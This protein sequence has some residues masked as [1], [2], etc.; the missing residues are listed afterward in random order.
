MGDYGADPAPNVDNARQ[1][2]FA[3]KLAALTNLKLDQFSTAG[4]DKVLSF[5]KKL[6]STRLQVLIDPTKF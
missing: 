3:Y 1:V 4:A 2:A 5:V 6:G